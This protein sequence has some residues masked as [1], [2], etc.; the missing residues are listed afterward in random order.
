M[1]A[2]DIVSEQASLKF[3][4]SCRFLPNFVPRMLVVDGNDSIRKACRE[5][6]ENCGLLV[7]DASDLEAAQ[8][9]LD[10]RLTDIVLLDVTNFESGCLAFIS[11]IKARQPDVTIIAMSAKATITSA[12]TT[13]QLGARD[14]MSKPFP[15]HVVTAALDRAVDRWRFEVERRRLNDALQSDIGIGETLGQSPEIEK[16]YQMLSKIGASS[17]SALIVGESGTGKRLVAHSIHSNSRDANL[18]FVSLTCK[19]LGE[20]LLNQELFGNPDLYGDKRFGLLASSSGGT[21]YLDEI[22]IM[23]VALQRRLANALSEKKYL[24]N[25]GSETVPVSVRLLAATSHDLSQMVRQGL[26]RMDLYRLLSIVNLKMPPLRE[27]P[28]DIAFLAKRFL[29]TI[30]NETGLS[31]TL[32]DETLQLLESYDWPDNL[33][34]LKDTIAQACA[35][36]EGQDLL[37]KHLPQKVL[38]FQRKKN[39]ERQSGMTSARIRRT[40]AVVPIARMEK[41]AI[42]NALRHT[43][44][45]KLLAAQLLGIGKTTLYRKLKEYGLALPI[46]TTPA[47]QAG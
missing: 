32:S 34:E 40:T 37:V 17:H 9:T 35:R 26:F 18:P 28:N 21:V 4:A 29:E 1:N 25:I 5:I 47:E 24:P 39:S 23:S 46:S 16:L 11:E 2:S 7:A 45:D 33:R 13:M 20:E 15:L 6:A 30:H 3:S 22:T 10:Q 43:S 12:V 36:S 38:N 8:K 41:R 14:Y 42:L 31:R 19:L 44:G 27:R